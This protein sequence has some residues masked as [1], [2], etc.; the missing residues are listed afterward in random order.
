MTKFWLAF[1]SAFV[2]LILFLNGGS[3]REQQLSNQAANSLS[4]SPGVA[5]QA[6]LESELGLPPEAR[7]ALLPSKS[8]SS[9]SSKSSSAIGVGGSSLV[10]A[11]NGS[12]IRRGDPADP[13]D[14]SV[15]FPTYAG[16][17]IVK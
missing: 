1:S 15:A 2:L 16:P 10:K 7:D 14:D 8:H 6:R 5:A 9:A 4:P 11:Y 3:W 13:G 17:E 12:P